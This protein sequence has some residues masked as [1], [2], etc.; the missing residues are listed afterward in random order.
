MPISRLSDP[1]PLD[2]TDKNYSCLQ[3]QR[4]KD[5]WNIERSREQENFL[6]QAQHLLGIGEG[7]HAGDIEARLCFFL[8]IYREETEIMYGGD[9]RRECWQ[10]AASSVSSFS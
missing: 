9:M 1:A 3:M 7:K 5:S 8:Q 6:R 2:V 10:R 4:L